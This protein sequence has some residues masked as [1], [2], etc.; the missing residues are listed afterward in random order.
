MKHNIIQVV[1]G[2]MLGLVVAVGV[3]ACGDKGTEQFRDAPR[4]ADLNNEPADILTMPDGFSNVAHKCDGPN[5]VYV[6]FHENRPYGSVA[7]APN[8][9]RCKG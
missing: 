9:P 7:V 3:A 2:L 6:I 1:V 4:G 5:M 8:D